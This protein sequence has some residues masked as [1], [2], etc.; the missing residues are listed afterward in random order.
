VYNIYSGSQ[1]DGLEL[2]DYIKMK[3]YSVPNSNPP[4]LVAPP[5]DSKPT[6]EIET[7]ELGFIGANSVRLQM[8]LKYYPHVKQKV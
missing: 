3:T 4:V 8:H 7:S 6:I 1:Y 2:P 5:V